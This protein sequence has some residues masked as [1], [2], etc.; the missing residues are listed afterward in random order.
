MKLAHLNVRS[1]TG[2]VHRLREVIL[3]Q[4]YDIVGISETWLSPAIST[5]ILNIDGY[6]FIRKD[7]SQRGVGIGGYLKL[8]EKGVFIAQSKARTLSKRCSAIECAKYRAIRC[9]N[10]FKIYKN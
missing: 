8:L 10:M 2:K 5:D 9:Y 4:R 7:R 1:L 3:D 6:T